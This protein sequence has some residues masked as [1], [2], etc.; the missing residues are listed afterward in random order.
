MAI[1]TLS[2]PFAYDLPACHAYLRVRFDG[3]NFWRTDDGAPGDMCDTLDTY[4]NIS[5]RD[6]TRA[7][8]NTNFNIPLKC[9]WHTFK[10]MTGG[11]YPKIYG[12]E[13]YMIT[14]PLSPGEDPG[15]IWIKARF[16]DSDPTWN[17]DDLYATFAEHPLGAYV[18]KMGE[19][20]AM[21]EAWK[22]TDEPTGYSESDCYARR[23][24]GKS[25]S[26]EASSFLTFSYS[27]YP[28]NCRDKPPAEGF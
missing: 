14:I 28:N 24:T 25:V 16:W 2:A 23:T 1:S 22:D 4:F 19:K 20:W 7:F 26:D 6:V 18:P 5:V 13:P 12:P 17:P 11:P 8:W 9:N 10:D 27:V 3:I 15:A 21:S